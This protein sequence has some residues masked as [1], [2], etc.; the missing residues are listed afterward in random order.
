[1]ESDQKESN[2][3][4]FQD[5]NLMLYRSILLAKVV[6]KIMLLL[7]IKCKVGFGSEINGFGATTLDIGKY[8]FDK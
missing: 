1:V 4:N 3:N 5:M 6:L 7:E 2:Y 8:L